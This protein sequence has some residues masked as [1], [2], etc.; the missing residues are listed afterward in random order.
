MASSQE[1]QAYNEAADWGGD[2]QAC[3]EEQEQENNQD[4]REGH[5]QQEGQLHAQQEEESALSEKIIGL[6]REVDAQKEKIER[7]EHLVGKLF[8]RSDYQW[9][10]AKKLEEKLE[11]VILEKKRMVHD[12]ETMEEHLL[13]I[14]AIVTKSKT[15]PGIAPPLQGIAPPLQGQAPPGRSDAPPVSVPESDPP[16]LAP[17][18][19]SESSEIALPVEPVHGHEVLEATPAQMLSIKIY[20][21]QKNPGSGCLQWRC[22]QCKSFLNDWTADHESSKTHR[23]KAWY[24]GEEY[25]DSM[26]EQ[27][28]L[29][30][31]DFGPACASTLKSREELENMDPSMKKKVRGP[32]GCII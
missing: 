13:G 5:H 11:G 8:K 31:N 6:E 29:D 9:D 3:N 30:L 28:Q 26:A 12:F 14:D 7:L 25:V 2:W 17:T 15:M 27:T 18:P 23:R 19:P 16:P 20:T 21:E 10:H 24:F 1:S 22:T 4:F 32:G